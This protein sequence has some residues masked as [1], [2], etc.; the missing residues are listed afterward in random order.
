[1]GLPVPAAG[2]WEFVA[3]AADI[4]CPDGKV[5][6]PGEPF[7]A[8]RPFLIRHSHLRRMGRLVPSSQAVAPSTVDTEEKGA[9]PPRALVLA[10]VED[11]RKKALVE[12]LEA[13]GLNPDD[14]ENNGERTTALEEWLA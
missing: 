13:I 10:A 12:A 6:G 5:R 1:M 2:S 14:F 11:G 9:P 8:D 4:L 3:P 7:E